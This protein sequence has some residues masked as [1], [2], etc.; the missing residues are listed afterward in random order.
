M[1]RSE[2]RCN[3][4]N[5][6]PETNFD[7]QVLSIFDKDLDLSPDALD[8]DVHSQLFWLFNIIN[9]MFSFQHRTIGKVRND[10]FVPNEPIL[11]LDIA[12]QRVKE[13]ELEEGSSV[14][15]YV[16]KKYRPE[17]LKGIPYK[18]VNSKDM[19]ISEKVYDGIELEVDEW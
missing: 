8:L 12:V 10:E 19:S 3:E 2:N 13:L 16:S 5:L 17:N 14:P 1:S 18:L 9:W 7:T 6:C 15:S 4:T 11:L